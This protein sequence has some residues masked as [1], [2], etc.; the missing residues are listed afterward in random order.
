MTR[1]AARFTFRA[2]HLLGLLTGVALAA[3]GCGMLDA[4]L[5]TRTVCFTRADYPIPAAVVPGTLST[6]IT[7]DVGND[8]PILSDQGV[9]YTLV[10]QRAEISVA[11]SSPAV[12]LG[13]VEELG[14]SIVAPAGSPLPEPELVRYVKGAEAHPT[15][16]VA[17]SASGDDLAPYVSGGQ[18]TFLA[19]ATGALP[20]RPWAADVTGCFLLTV[21]VNYGKKL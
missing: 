6:D 7:Y 21:D 16:I 12:D 17:A 18:I 11:Q 1:D 3:S 8:L 5:E 2:P 9:Q 10:L 15:T 20:S 19:T 13:G 14:I 4:K